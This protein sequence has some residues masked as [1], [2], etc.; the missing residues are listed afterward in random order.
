MWDFWE[1]RNYSYTQKN[2]QK[3]EMVAE[4]FVDGKAVCEER[5]MPS[6]RSTKLRLTVDWQGRPLTADG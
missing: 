4:G 5:K 3:V 6:R 2:W 1:A